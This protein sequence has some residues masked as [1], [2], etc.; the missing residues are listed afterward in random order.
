MDENGMC[1]QVLDDTESYAEV[2]ST[3]MCA[4]AFARGIRLGILADN[5][6]AQAAAKAVDSLCRYC[7]DCEGNI[8]GV[9]VGS[10]YSFRRDYYKYELPWNVNDTHGTGIVLIALEEV[11]NLKKR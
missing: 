6:Y 3:A 11:E 4:A 10:G 2:S 7:I 5:K 9:C 8:Y 1:H